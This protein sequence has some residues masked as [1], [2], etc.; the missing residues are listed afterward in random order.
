[1]WIQLKY[2]TEISY[3]GRRWFQIWWI[4]IENIIIAELLNPTDD[5]FAWNAKAF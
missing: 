1:M 2:S 3:D 4:I 5:W